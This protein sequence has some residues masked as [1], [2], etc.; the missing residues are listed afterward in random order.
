MRLAP[1][2][3]K[4]AQEMEAERTGAVLAKVDVTENSDLGKRFSIEGCVS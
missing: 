3:D 2:F 4:L 1:V